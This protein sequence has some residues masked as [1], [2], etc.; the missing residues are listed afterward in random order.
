MVVGSGHS[1]FHAL[2]ELATLADQ[3]PGTEITWAVRRAQVGQLFGGEENDALPE[4]GRLGT[5][6]SPRN[7][8]WEPWGGNPVGGNPGNPG[9][10]GARN[11]GH[12]STAK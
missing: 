12:T 6:T 5:A 8:G 4:R 3:A 2:L 9:N 7:V 11:V 10:V 1:A